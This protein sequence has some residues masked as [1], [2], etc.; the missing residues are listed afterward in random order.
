MLFFI[1]GRSSVGKDTIF[2]RLRE[3]DPSLKEATPCTTRPM[4]EGER[5][6]VEYFFVTDEQFLKDKEEGK[7]LEYRQ[8][9]S[10]HGIWTYYTRFSAVQ[11]EGDYIISGSIDMFNKVYDVLGDCVIP[12]YIKLPEVSL[13]ERALAREKS[14]GEG[15]D[16]VEMCRRFL[17]ESKDYENYNFNGRIKV[18]FVN[19]DLAVCVEEIYNYINELRLKDKGETG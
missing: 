4:R 16:I 7:I 19:D 5:E 17:Q 15:A 2:R 18:E 10:S 3:M 13:I 6:G 12:I 9:P 14:R 11:G 8:Y 1:I